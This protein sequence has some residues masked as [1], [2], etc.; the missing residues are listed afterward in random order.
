MRILIDVMGA[1]KAPEE[2]IR[3]VAQAYGK[4]SS[5]IIIAG[6]ESMI[7]EALQKCD[8]DA[9]D[10]EILHCEQVITMEDNPRSAVREKKNS[11]MAKGLRYVAEGN[12]DAYVGAGSTGAL[13]ASATYII[14][15]IKGIRRAA[16]ATVLP[17][18]KPLLLLDSGANLSV[19]GEFAEQFAIMGSLYAKHILNVNSPKVGV[20]NNGSEEHKGTL[21]AL[22]MHAALKGCEDIDFIGNVEGKDV[23]FGVCDVLVTDGFT[24]NIVL[25]YTE[26][27]ASFFMD[28]LKGVFTSGIASKLAYLMVKSELKKMK[29]DFS[30]SQY[31]GAPFIGLSKPVIKAHGSSDGEA[32]KNAIL[33]AESFYNSGLTD[34]IAEKASKNVKVRQ[35]LEKSC[36][37]G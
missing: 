26:G 33:Q 22:E 3:G 27:L 20:L 34:I 8:A 24:G 15:P 36:E 1:D 10:F 30:A 7:K 28:R 23:P 25:K 5:K 12:A 19:S 9:S 37:E 2:L 17:L 11:S 13:F 21:S 14:K 16:I 29:K 35:R 32:I 18:Q 6:D 31:G 4:T